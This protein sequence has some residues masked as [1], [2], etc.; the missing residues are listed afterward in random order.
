MTQEQQTEK[1]MIDEI[2]KQHCVNHGCL[3]STYMNEGLKKAF[4]DSMWDYSRRYASSLVPPKEAKRKAVSPIHSRWLF[5]ANN[6]LP[7]EEG[8][9]YVMD[10]FGHQGWCL[11]GNSGAPGE[12][13]SFFD[14]S[15]DDGIK[16]KAKDIVCWMDG[17]DARN[18]IKE[19]NEKLM[20]KP[21]PSVLPAGKEEGRTTEE[22][23]TVTKLTLAKIEILKLKLANGGYDFSLI[24][25]ENQDQLDNTLAEIE[26][27]LASSLRSRQEGRGE[28]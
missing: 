22:V 11:Y 23:Q 9:V 21:F 20:K 25:K 12:N 17:Q 14:V 8:K 27:L 26:T 16:I 7:D 13:T 10:K 1:D 6:E 3:S 18:A 4:Y 5:I 24:G 15:D 28:K 2:W 19:A